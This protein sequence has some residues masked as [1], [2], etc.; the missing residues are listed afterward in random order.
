MT[1]K[2][3]LCGGDHYASDC[4]TPIAQQ[5]S[6]NR[7]EPP[8]RPNAGVAVWDL[9]LADMRE[10]DAIGAR[11]Y[12]TRL[13]AGD[14]RDSLIDA[15]QES[16]DQ[17]VYLRKEIEERR[18]NRDLART[19]PEHPESRDR[20]LVLAASRGAFVACGQPKKTIA[21]AARAFGYEARTITGDAF[22]TAFEW[23]HQN[24]DADETAFGMAASASSRAKLAALHKLARAVVAS[25]NDLDS[26]PGDPDPL[27]GALDALAAG[28][29]PEPTL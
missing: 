4:S 24:I 16:L 29:G 15:Y 7:P 20:D 13:C 22:E 21:D 2:C 26:R 23:A 8:P 1:G 28:L 3:T 17:V 14:G 18:M 6:P 11:K 25:R 19:S 9:V 5:A 12:G 27:W 10:R